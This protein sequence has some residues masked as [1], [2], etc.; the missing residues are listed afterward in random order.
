MRVFLYKRV[1]TCNQT[2]VNCHYVLSNVIGD[3]LLIKVQTNAGMCVCVC[4]CGRI[5]DG[6]WNIQSWRKNQKI[7]FALI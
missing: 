6:H 5:K 1:K 7:Y 2:I 3:T 4:V